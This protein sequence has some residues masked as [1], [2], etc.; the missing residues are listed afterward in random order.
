MLATAV[1]TREDFEA[2]LAAAREVGT[3]T[4]GGGLASQLG[5][6][7]TGRIQEVW[8]HIDSALSRAYQ[9]GLEKA[10]DSLDAAVQ[11]AEDLLA[12]VGRQAS[13]VHQELMA[14][15]ETY[16]S[17]IIDRALATVRPTVTIG[18]RTLQLEGVDLSQTISLSGSLKATIT[19]MVNLT[20]SGQIIV[21]A[22]YSLTPTA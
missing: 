11:A 15:V 3:V 2:A 19:D 12:S 9:Y 16:L 8:D 20:A 18:S 13:A 7:L 5:A 4:V 10:R 22:R 14:R 17:G 21:N 6:S 1:I